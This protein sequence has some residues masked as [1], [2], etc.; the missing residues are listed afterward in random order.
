MTPLLAAIGYTL[1]YSAILHGLFSTAFQ[2]DA[3]T[4]RTR[5]VITGAAETAGGVIGCGVLLAITGGFL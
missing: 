2:L 5:P 3:E 1:A 4:M